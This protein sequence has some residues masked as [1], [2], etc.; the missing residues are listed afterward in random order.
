LLIFGAVQ[1]MRDHIRFYLNGQPHEVRGDD[2]FLTVSDYLRGRI[3]KAGTKVVCAEGDCGACTVLAGRYRAGAIVYEPIDSCI[4][5]LHQVD[6][7]HVITVEGLRDNG[8]LHPVQ[9]ALLDNHGSQCGYCT[10]GIVMALAGWADAGC[11]IDASAPRLP[12]TGNLCRCTGY[13]PIFEAADTLARAR[14]MRLAAR[15]DSPELLKA[16]AATSKEPLRIES[17]GRLYFAPTTLAEAVA[18]KAGH[19]DAVIVAGATELGVWRNKKNHEPRALL[20]LARIVELDVVSAGSE[21]IVFGANVTWT[22][23]EHAVKEPLPEFIPIIQRFGS[24]QIRNAGTLAGNVANGSP[25]A[26]SLAL[27]SVLDASIELVGPRGKRQRSINGFYT[28]YKQ[29]DVAAD[30][31]ITRII[32]PLPTNEDRLRLTKVSRRRDMDIATFGSAVLIRATGGTITRAAAAFIGVAPTVV[33]LPKTEAFLQGREFAE[34]TFR[35]AGRIARTEI[36]PLT[37][38]RGSRDFRL[39]L[40]ENVFAKFYFEA[41]P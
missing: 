24:P 5:F 9:Q 17:S 18:F 21:Q 40:A 4:Q 34:G 35:Q 19:P 11:T 31:L 13:L 22:G 12:L 36:Q 2:A 38:V 1:V 3:G 27:L 25:I 28:G 29:K 39:Q 16:L 7:K 14:P 30:E 20:S 41:N 15:F 37:D 26:D 23:V 6:G 33:R 10:P 8:R 32:V